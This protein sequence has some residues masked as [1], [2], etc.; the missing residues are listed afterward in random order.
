MGATRGGTEESL[1]VRHDF[2]TVA[3]RGPGTTSL[4][5]SPTTAA[6]PPPATMA[7][8][9][10]AM[11][12]MVRT[13]TERE[14]Y[15]P[16]LVTPS[17]GSSPGI[18]HQGSHPGILF[19]HAHDEYENGHDITAG[20]GRAWASATV[21]VCDIVFD[22]RSWCHVSALNRPNHLDSPECIPD[23]RPAITDPRLV[24]P[25]LLPPGTG[26]SLC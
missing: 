2:S 18:F 17:P 21:Q 14:P 16:T 26:A 20:C 23:P 1:A 24:V 12:P 10:H 7:R 3:R 13:T 15:S 22:V 4:Q 25:N 19:T 5:V 8:G 9:R 11:W 6:V